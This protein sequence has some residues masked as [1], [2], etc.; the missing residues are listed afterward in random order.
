VEVGRRDPGSLLSWFQRAISALRECPEMT[1][2]SCRYVDTGDRAVLALVHDAPSG[3]VLA[4]VNLGPA[5]RTVD[6]GPLD[7]QDGDPLEVFADRDY[8]AIGPTLD[9]IDV[10][11]HGYRWIRLRRSI[12]GRAGSARRMR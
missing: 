12:G 8:A 5:K 6:I 3:A 1:A 9:H 10:A 7:E 4:V 2:G 11:G